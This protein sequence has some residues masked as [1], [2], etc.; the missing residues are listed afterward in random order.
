MFIIYHQLKISLYILFIVAVIFGSCQKDTGTNVSITAVDLAI[1]NGQLKGSWLFPVQTLSVVDS[2]GHILS[3]SQ[4]TSAPAFQFD[5]NQKVN[6]ITD[7]HSTLTGTYTLSTSKGS[8]YLNIVYPNGTKEQ[9]QVLLINDQTLKLNSVQ[10]HTYYNGSTPVPA[11]A[12]INTELKKQNS[13]DVTGSFIRVMVKSDSI[14]NVG[15]YVIHKNPGDTAILLNSKIN[16]IGSYNY[17]FV[18]K[19]GDHLIIDV[20]GSITRTYLFAYYNGLPFTGQVNT[21]AQ[22]NEIITGIGWSIP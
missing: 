20:Y 19:P 2:T 1:M 4:N 8:I 22:R 13:A 6:I 5:G 11:T 14:Y 17:A 21:S 15:V 9:Y 16:V 12:I 3:P 10:H 18:S 7:L